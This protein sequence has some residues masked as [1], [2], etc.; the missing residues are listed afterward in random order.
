[1]DFDLLKMDLDKI[2]ENLNKLKLAINIES[3]QKEIEKLEKQTLVDGFWNDIA[4][5]SEVMQ[6]IKLLKRPID[7][8][9]YL[10]KIYND[11]KDYLDIAIE[12]ND[13]ESYNE[14]EK[15]IKTLNEKIEK[16]TIETLFSD[17]YDSHNA[18][19]TIHPGAGGTESH[20]W[21]LMLY[22]MYTKWAQNSDFEVEV[23]DMQEGEEAG[24]NSVSFMIKGYNAYGYLKGEKGVHR[25]VRISPFDANSRRHTSF[26]AVEILPEILDDVTVQIRS[27]DLEVDTYRA[28]GAG[29]QHINKTDS[30]VRIKHVPSG[31]VV[32][33]QTERSQLQNKDN[34]MKMLKAK[35]YQLEKENMN[36]KIQD[37]K[38]K[39]SDNAWGSQIRSYVFCPYTLVK[40]HRT[41]YETGNIQA[42][43]DGKLDEFMYEYLRFLKKGENN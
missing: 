30:A 2:L 24:I 41:N 18:I 42:V 19:V 32:T 14:A 9:S 12:E 34:A 39:L 17:E 21:A 10:E 22:R 35:L 36:T 29:G 23:L 11:A 6:K 5:S 27:E 4:L 1:M 33:C 31:I 37:L 38:G 40:D 43:M 3:K 13:K 8:I 26:A 20:D 16:Y 15:N 25:L 28:S 7:N